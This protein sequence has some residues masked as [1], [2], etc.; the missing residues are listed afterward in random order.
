MY[1]GIEAVMVCIVDMNLT[2]TALATSHG[3]D[4]KGETTALG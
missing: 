3:D 1:K 4:I 2:E